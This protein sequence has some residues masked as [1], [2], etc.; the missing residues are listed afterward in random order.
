MKRPNRVSSWRW[1]RKKTVPGAAE[2]LGTDG[3]PE[4]PG[5]TSQGTMAGSPLST[6]TAESPPV[7]SDDSAPVASAAEERGVASPRWWPERYDAV[8][9]RWVEARRRRV[10]SDPP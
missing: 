7:G 4:V 2:D 10:R 3:K 1:C 9:A 8:V 6:Q 5:G